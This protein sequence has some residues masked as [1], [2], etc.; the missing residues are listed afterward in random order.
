[1]HLSSFGKLPLRVSLRG[2]LALLGALLFAGCVP[3]DD[4]GRTRLTFAVYGSLEQLKREEALVEAFEQAN[5]DIEIDLLPITAGR[6]AE[7]IQAMFVGRV[8]PDVMMLEFTYYHD[9]AARGAL[10]DL[11]PEAT[12]LQADNPYMPLVQRAFTRD[13]RY[14]ALPINF[15]G[16]VTYA[17][18]DAFKA[19]GIPYPKD[20]LT[21]QQIE[22][23]GP[24]LS[25]AA[26]N[27]EAT[28]EYALQMLDVVAPLWTFG[29]RIFDDLKHP[30]RVEVNSPATVEFLE[31]SRRVYRAPWAVPPSVRA[32]HGNY[33]IF[34]DGLV[35]L[36]IGGRWETPNLLGRTNFTWDIL[37]FPAGPAGPKPL[38][39]GTG[40]AVSNDT[41]HP[42]AAR[43]FARFYASPESAR[44]AM[45]GGRT[46]PPYRSLVY[47]SEFLHLPPEGSTRH[48]GRAME[49]G[50]AEFFLYRPGARPVRQILANR[51]EQAVEVQV[52]RPVEEI[53][54]LLETDLQRWLDRNGA[55]DAE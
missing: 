7:K 25:R 32:D 19:A 47:G 50:A 6:F 53:V 12:E 15:A 5:P 26:G 49:H 41:R 34:R 42:E 28:T 48:L 52:Y 29:G 27:P 3:R 9:W 40:I 35:A 46:V 24:K 10:L 17:N 13:E 55:P 37:P 31:F 2:L 44:I 14:Y 20:G 30:T 8:A 1:M 21:W 39:N 45:R 38:H 23:L 18:V 22:E 16:Y 54:S 51:I 11:T 33:Q 43:R 36:F 4:D